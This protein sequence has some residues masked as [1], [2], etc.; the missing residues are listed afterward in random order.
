M[1]SNRNSNQQEDVKNSTTYLS[2]N[3]THN[4]LQFIAKHGMFLFTRFY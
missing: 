1:I 3:K 2:E 4:M